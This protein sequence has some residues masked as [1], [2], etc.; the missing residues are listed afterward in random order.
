MN[1][2]SGDTVNLIIDSLDNNQL[3]LDMIPYKTTVFELKQKLVLT[4]P[5]KPE[6]KRMKLV[7]AGKMLGEDSENLEFLRKR[8]TF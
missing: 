7:L 5:G 1:P 6:L 4:H 3:H 2:R 8:K